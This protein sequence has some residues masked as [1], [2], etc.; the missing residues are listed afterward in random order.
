MTRACVSLAQGKFTAAW[1]YHPFAFFI[2]PLALGI[3]CAPA[4]LGDTWL[5]LSAPIRNTLAGIGITLV[6]GLWIYH[7]TYF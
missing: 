7:L 6:L 3:S 2:V 1:H 4:R 5:K